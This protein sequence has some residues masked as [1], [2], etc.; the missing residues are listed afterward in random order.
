ME[1]VK[2]RAKLCDLT[3]AVRAW[4]RKVEISEVLPYM[5]HLCNN[6]T[7]L[8]FSVQMALQGLKKQWRTL[9][10]RATNPWNALD[11][12]KATTLQQ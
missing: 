10:N 11:P 8:C 3:K 4:G 5:Y 1:Y 6:E 9:Q 2:E 12:M 7:C